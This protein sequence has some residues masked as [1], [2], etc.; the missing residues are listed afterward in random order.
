M[1]SGGGGGG[2]SGGSSHFCGT[3]RLATATRSFSSITLQTRTESFGMPLTVTAFR[4]VPGSKVVGCPLFPGAGA[5]VFDRP[6]GTIC[7][8]RLSFV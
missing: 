6:S 8:A 7:S 1:V 3:K 5:K 2:G 4:T